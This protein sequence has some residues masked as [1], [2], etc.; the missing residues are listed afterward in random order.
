VQ[1]LPPRKAGTTLASLAAG[2]RSRQ[3][4]EPADSRALGYC[5]PAPGSQPYAPAPARPHLRA[6]TWSGERGGRDCGGGGGGSD[7]DS[8]DVAGV[9]FGLLGALGVFGFTNKRAPLSGV[10]RPVRGTPVRGGKDGKRGRCQ[11]LPSRPLLRHS[12]FD[13]DAPAG[14]VVC[15]ALRVSPSGLARVALRVYPA[16]AALTLAHVCVC[17]RVCVCVCVRARVR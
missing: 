7:N 8:N 12:R 17:V 9:S 4:P 10:C 3:A 16:P 11:V 2:N 14:R 15:K 5:L 6:R 1:S 13:H